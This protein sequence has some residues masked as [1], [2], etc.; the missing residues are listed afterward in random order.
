MHDA[1][2][3][4]GRA[5]AVGAGWAALH[6]RPKCIPAIAAAWLQD[7]ETRGTEGTRCAV[8][9]AAGSGHPLRR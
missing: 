3:V 6:L 8:T 4:R 1:A 5:G 7:A 2:V 9:A